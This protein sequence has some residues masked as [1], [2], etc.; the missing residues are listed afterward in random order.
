[1]SKRINRFGHGAIRST[2]YL[3]T[4]FASS[5]TAT[6]VNW[7]ELADGYVG[8]VGASV[9]EAAGIFTFPTTGLWRVSFVK[10]SYLGTT[11]C[12]YVYTTIEATLNAT[13][14]PPT[15]NARQSD[16]GSF[17]PSNVS[18][19]YH[20]GQASCLLQIT[21]TAEQKVKT[22]HYAGAVVNVDSG[23]PYTAITFERLED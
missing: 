20:S 22:S 18:N 17:H 10:N 19:T 7:T 8:P 5:S 23:Y 3:N 13:G 12:R 1:M 11:A 6:I 15:W 16:L 14:G 9:T 4:L 2:W 21:D